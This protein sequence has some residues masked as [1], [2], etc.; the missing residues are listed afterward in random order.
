M[1]L[2]VRIDDP[3]LHLAQAKSAGVQI[4]MGLAD[5]DSGSR[6][7]APRDLEGNMWSFGT[8]DPYTTAPSVG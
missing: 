4:T 7:Y 6:E 2:H 3:D 8:Y 5:Q 1:G